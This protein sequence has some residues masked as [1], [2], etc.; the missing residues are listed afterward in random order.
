L[1]T[2]EDR[3]FLTGGKLPLA[4]RAVNWYMRRLIRLSSVDRLALDAFT[5]VVHIVGPMSD[6]FQPR[7]AW[8]VVTTAPTE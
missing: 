7:L 4:E 5:N 3:A 2:G 1:S 8:K 6:L